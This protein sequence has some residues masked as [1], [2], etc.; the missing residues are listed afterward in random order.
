[1]SVTRGWIPWEATVTMAHINLR[2]HAG[3]LRDERLQPSPLDDKPPRQRQGLIPTAAEAYSTPP[4]GRQ[5][6]P[7][8]FLDSLNHIKW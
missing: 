2:D 4:A 3:D 6:F 1:M 7:P 5:I 8:A